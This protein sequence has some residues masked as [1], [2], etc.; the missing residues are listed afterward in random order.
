MN[1]LHESVQLPTDDAISSAAHRVEFVRE[2]LRS[3][4]QLI[5]LLDQKS[6]L[7]LVIMGVTSA[8]F[9]STTS[10]SLARIETLLSL[11]SIVA[12]MAVWFMTEAG[13]VLWYSLKSIQGVVAKSVAMEAPSM[14]FP[15]SLLRAYDHDP[16]RY[17]ERL[18][19]LDVDEIL[20]D[21]SVEIVKTS[22]IFVEKTVQVN[23]AVKA[24]FRSMLPW[25]VGILASILSRTM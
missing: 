8:A 15:H 25:I 5:Q 12:L 18:R 9:Y 7:I 11:P 24:L 10:G 19:T 16:Q 13:I 20:R 17:F 22:T 4:Q 1:H 2:T 3:I 6:Y 14:V 23:D 21:Y